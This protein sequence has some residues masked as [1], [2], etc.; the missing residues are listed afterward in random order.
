MRSMEELLVRQGTCCEAVEAVLSVWIRRLFRQA[1][2]NQRVAEEIAKSARL[3]RMQ[4][5]LQ[6]TPQDKGERAA[7]K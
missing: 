1:H 6:T 5:E 3:A 4:E 7:G 2:P